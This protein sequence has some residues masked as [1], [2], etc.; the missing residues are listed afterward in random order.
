MELSKVVFSPAQKAHKKEETA[1][2]EV[3][4]NLLYSFSLNFSDIAENYSL[5]IHMNQPALSLLPSLSFTKTIIR[6]DSSPRHHKPPTKFSCPFV[7]RRRKV[8]KIFCPSSRVKHSRFTF[9][10]RTFDNTPPKRKLPSR[11]ER[12][13]YFWFDLNWIWEGGGD[14]AGSGGKLLK[15][16]VV[17]IVFVGQS[18][19]AAQ[20]TIRCWN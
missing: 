10:C 9:I 12:N 2:A 20:V 8:A 15:N 18:T 17:H 6:F 7:L 11:H 19:T 4:A 16:E 1:A 14:D 5:F 13:T 3:D